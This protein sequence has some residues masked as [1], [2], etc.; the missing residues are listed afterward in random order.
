MGIADAANVLTMGTHNS[1]GSNSKCPSPSVNSECSSNGRLTSST[2]SD[3]DQDIDHGLS[4][5][6]NSNQN[7]ITSSTN[8]NNNCTN[9]NNS[10]SNKMV[11]LRLQGSGQYT[12]DTDLHVA[13][14]MSL[15]AAAAAAVAASRPQDG[16]DNSA[17][18][19][20][21]VQAAVVNLAAAMRMNNPSNGPTAYQQHVSTIL[22][23]K[24]LK[25]IDWPNRSISASCLSVLLYKIN[26]HFSNRTTFGL[27]MSISGRYI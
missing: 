3:Q 22:G 21:A 23:E 15:M 13:N 8:N 11:E 26:P 9:N 27:F 6:E 20:A 7:N 12:M 14:R 5:N 19:S 16:V 4:E 25:T 17:V 2:T 10:G 18:P 1:E 24:P